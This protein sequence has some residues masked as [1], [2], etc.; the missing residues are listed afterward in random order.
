M[1]LLIYKAAR[2]FTAKEQSLGNGEKVIITFNFHQPENIKKISI[3]GQVKP[4]ITRNEKK[5]VP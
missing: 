1:V 4:L 5:K 2:N 3:T